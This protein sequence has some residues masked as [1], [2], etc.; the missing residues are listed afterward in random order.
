MA[1]VGLERLV[2][3]V[4]RS[5]DRVFFINDWAKTAA[6]CAATK[7]PSF[8][9]N[10]VRTAK[11]SAITF[12]PLNLL[13]QFRRVANVYF[14]VISLLQLTTSLSPTN[15]YSTIGPLAV[16]LAVT[17]VKEGIEDKARHDADRLVNHRTTERFVATWEREQWQK[18][19]V[20]DIVRI[21]DGDALP[22]DVVLVLSSQGDHAHI[23][24]SNLDGEANAKL[25]MCLPMSL[26]L[27]S[28]A[29]LSGCRVTCDVPNSKLSR[30][31]GVFS[32]PGGAAGVQ[33]V[34]DI[35]FSME[36]VL[37]RGTSLCHTSWVVGIVVATGPDTK[38][39]Q[40]SRQPAAKFSQIDR[41]ANRCIGAMIAL[42][43]VAVTASAAA[44]V[45]FNNEPHVYLQAPG[46]P[47]SAKSS[48]GELWIT[49]LILY[50]NLV[51]I[52]LY[53]TLEVVKWCQARQIEAD[54]ALFCRET[55]R[56]AKAMTSNLNEDL[57]Q[58]N[59]LFTDK[60]GT[61]TTNQMVLRASSIDGIIFD[62][63]A[64]CEMSVESLDL[65]WELRAAETMA[66]AATGN[67]PSSGILDF[68]RCVLLCH[69]ATRND[70]G[71]LSSS[72]PDE[73]ALL[74]AFGHIGAIFHGRK[75]N[76]VHVSLFGLHEHYQILALNEFDSQR[77]CMSVVVRRQSPADATIASDA[78]LV[79]CKG[80]DAVLLASPDAATT[81]LSQHVHHFACI[82]LRTLVFAQQRLSPAQMSPA[83]MELWTLPLG[84]PA[85]AWIAQVEDPTQ[86]QVL[87]TTGVEDKL[88]AG[89]PDAL[90]TLAMA[91]IRVW[92]LTGDKDET[93]VA[94]GHSSGLLSNASTV[95]TIHGRSTDE[96]MD[97]ITQHRR[98]LKKQGLWNIHA[99][100]PTLAVVVNGFALDV[101]L[102]NPPVKN[103]EPLVELLVQ[104]HT[105]IACRLSPGQKATLVDL[106]KR[107]SR[108][109][110]T[111]AM[112]D[113][114][115]D[116][117]MIQAANV[118]IGIYGK[119]GLHAVRSADIGLGQFRFV[120]PL[121]LLH[122]RWSH[123]RLCHVLLFTLYKNVVLVATLALFSISSGFSGQTL[124]DSYL[125]VGWNIVYTAA[126]VFVVG[127]VDHDIQAQTA[128]RYPQVYPE[129]EPIDGRKLS[130]W[131]A[132]AVV[133][134]SIIQF[135]VVKML[136]TSR[137]DDGGVYFVGTVVFLQSL[138]AASMKAAMI[139]Q[140]WHR[141]QWLH[142]A[143]LACGP[144]F[145]VVFVAVYANLYRWMPHGNV[146]RDFY[147]LG[148]AFVARG[149]DIALVTLLAPVAAVLPDVAW[150]AFQRLYF[151]S[152][153]HLLQEIDSNLGEQA[154]QTVTPL[155][156]STAASND[157]SLAALLHAVHA[158]PASQVAQLISQLQRLH[159]SN[160]ADPEGTLLD[161]TDVRLHPTKMEFVG[162]A[163][164]AVEIEFEAAIV[165]HERNRVRL[166][167]Y[168]ATALLL[169][170]LLVEF[171]IA[172]HERT[173]LVSRLVVVGGAL[174]YAQLTRLD[175]FT[176]HYHAAILCP[177]VVT[178]AVV[179]ATIT[180][181]GYVSAVLFPI[182][183]L[184]IL[185]VQFLPSLVLACANFVLYAVI[186]AARGALDA[187]QLGAIT[188]YIG[189]V[190]VFAAHGSWRMQRAMRD[191]FLQHR[192]L[193]NQERRALQILC[194]MF[195]PHVTAKLQ[196]GDSIVAEHEPDVTVLFCDI[197]DL[198]D[199]MH[200]NAPVEVVSLLDHIYS[201]FDEICVKFHVQKMETVGKTYM[202]C[203][204]LHETAT[205]P[206]M[207]HAALRAACLATEMLR[208]MR[209]CR[210]P[211][212]KTIRIRIG[213]HTGN[214]LS[215]LVGCKKQQFSLFGDT[216]N[217]A[218][219]MQTTGDMDAC[220]VS[221]ATFD[222]LRGD[223]AF[224]PRV[225]N[226]KGKGEMTAY[227][228]GDPTSKQAVAF[229]S[230]PHLGSAPRFDH[231]RHNAIMEA[232][233]N[234]LWLRF[235]EPTTETAYV[236]STA[237]VRAAGAQRTLYALGLYTIFALVR[238]LSRHDR[239][240]IVV[241]GVVVRVVFVL[242]AGI[243]LKW[244]LEWQKKIKWLAL[245]ALLSLVLFHILVISKRRAQHSELA[246]QDIDLLA[247]DLVWVIFAL[248]NSGALSHRD[249]I[250]FNLGVWIIGVPLLVFGYFH[251]KS[252]AVIYPMILTTCSAI[253]GVTISRRTE[254]F[255]RR[256][257]WLHM[258]TQLETK[259]ADQLLYQRLPEAVVT[260]LKQGE[261]ICDEHLMVSILYSD[262][263]GFTSIASRAN[264][265]Q[266]I[267]ML[268]K[269]FAAFDKLTEKN[270][271]FKLQTIGDA[272]VIVSGLP[273]VDM[274]A[275][276]S[277]MDAL[278]R[279]DTPPME[280]IELL[281]LQTR[282][283]SLKKPCLRVDQHLQ[284][285]LQM[286][287]DMIHHVAQVQD[288]NTGKPLQMRIGV[289]LGS[290][291]GGVI[292]NL[293]LR[294]DM[295]G[296]DKEESL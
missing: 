267:H 45:H 233:I 232:A 68:L 83:Q 273:Y 86:M 246:E 175:L 177:M 249:A 157:S 38:L 191:D 147:G 12:V 200:D 120:V 285:L 16:V 270:G 108:H 197:V 256:T 234:P 2:S 222:K 3:S 22:A 189:F 243:A 139:M 286:A 66:A 155:H 80:A 118:G 109:N 247:L 112:G 143:A 182:V 110:V 130:F 129:M 217:T 185:Y 6:H 65:P 94:L 231:H 171:F 288:P 5:G 71:Q 179:S 57:G 158:A 240:G 259:K 99:V 244:R 156:P 167:V 220:Q 255:T 277:R 141:W 208:L 144:A 107:Q 51:P 263:K 106:V 207:P 252:S 190:I 206:S 235:K 253:A 95:V 31:D 180:D 97:E 93:A 202:A 269:L 133:Q 146:F 123:R 260:R 113:G 215:G 115:N 105:V 195:P 237:G 293:T 53:V 218:S 210:T 193:V 17:L 251:H 292:G 79:Y 276:G 186:Q 170:S 37:L 4:D 117:S 50:N 188:C 81:I 32:L 248:S 74:E 96:C 61:L 56:P 181:T 8:P 36:N 201:L 67:S 289:H 229:L 245:V 169:T 69:T 9:S 136:P 87:G 213:L 11:Y 290:I 226:V 196:A 271:V 209:S 73:C 250:V 283:N 40:N 163:R 228:M 281:D 59:Y 152:N 236:K 266:V 137:L 166:C 58:I 42:L 100:L 154:F 138:L 254:F 46:H 159:A 33:E 198:H 128:R 60:T 192:A 102:G 211:C 19:H 134:A 70:D 230:Q 265:D 15:K 82:G 165:A 280:Q 204:G 98:M 114:G 29:L 55:K 35:P 216:V 13:E 282:R 184:T 41:V 122:G 278:H 116:V 275:S 28:I 25:K 173:F 172:T 92:M 104:A 27:P 75:G 160:R 227:L 296:P 18:L 126:P 153:R 219:R 63:A 149:A 49:Y 258:Q 20:G 239:G 7:T 24:T 274:G 135:V 261:V 124:F 140:R 264:T 77:R 174:A 132:S 178:G 43:F 1:T 121:L 10:V 203:A 30:F 125:I 199:L 54:P 88:Q 183:L 78:A 23:E 238:D 111:L 223:F 225:V 47:K 194:N 52:S 39:M 145:F 64:S 164:R 294:Y 76:L 161:A 101:L 142:I 44:G 262:V 151:F 21:R 242:L 287:L 268:D 34:Q 241:V 162:K 14:L 257:M 279:Q 119:E 89:V 205:D 90:E 48:F 72:S 91:G 131:L 127:V 26:S 187:W 84:T 295:W 291:Y 168:L 214:V 85:A 150:F 284:N 212:G 148:V 176:R 224:L 221:E 62:H 103:V 272:Y